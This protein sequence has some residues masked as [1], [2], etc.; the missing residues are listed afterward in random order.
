MSEK[1]CK[2]CGQEFNNNYSGSATDGWSVC[3]ER[4]RVA[5]SE[6]VQEGKS[7][8]R[9]GSSGFGCLG[10]LVL[11]VLAGGLVSKCGSHA[12]SRKHARGNQEQ[13][14]TSSESSSTFTNSEDSAP[15]AIVSGD[16]AS[17]PETR[18]ESSDSENKSTTT[19]PA[20]ES[21]SEQAQAM[22][23]STSPHYKTRSIMKA[24]GLSRRVI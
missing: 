24:T 8:A 15:E 2:W 22:L 4:C 21:P 10:V 6:S 1:L 12:S 23:Q 18:T 13:A 20:D 17:E 14:S 3:S 7:E 5:L 16:G 11:L 9:S 19:E